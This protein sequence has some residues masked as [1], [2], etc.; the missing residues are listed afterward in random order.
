[1]FIYW[2]RGEEPLELDDSF[3]LPDIPESDFGM[4]HMQ[5]LRADSINIPEK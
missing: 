5:L 3:P 1:M 2:M 4:T